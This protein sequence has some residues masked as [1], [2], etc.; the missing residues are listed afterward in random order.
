MLRIFLDYRFVSF[1]EL[2]Q[3]RELIV[4]REVLSPRKGSVSIEDFVDCLST[5]ETFQIMRTLS[6]YISF[7]KST[8][9]LLNC[10]KL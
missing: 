2:E 4:Q 3:P 10:S 9:A 5:C 6:T 8:I 1:E 7:W